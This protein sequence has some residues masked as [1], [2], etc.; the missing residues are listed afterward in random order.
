MKQK[1][2]VVMLPTTEATLNSLVEYKDNVLAYVT[3]MLDNNH[4]KVYIPKDNSY[5]IEND[6]TVKP[7]HL[8]FLS[9]E[10]IKEGDWYIWGNGNNQIIQ[11]NNLIGFDDSVKEHC[12]KIIATTDP[13][14]R[15]CCGREYPQNCVIENKCP[16][17]PKVLSISQQD[18]PKIVDALNKGVT[19]VGI[20][21]YDGGIMETHHKG[22]IQT[23]DGCI[24]LDWGVEKLEDFQG[25]KILVN[26]DYSGDTDFEEGVEVFDWGI[27]K[28]E[29]LTPQQVIDRFGDHLTTEQWKTLVKKMYTK[30]EVEEL[31][32]SA[33][34]DNGG[35][36]SQEQITR[37]KEWIKENLKL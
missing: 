26:G 19:S 20:K 30:E 17:Y 35:F 27:I 16:D 5:S 2:P 7:Q 11:A 13:K 15:P 4:Y 14:L 25:D 9:D 12:K 24:V 34:E 10:K 6:T 23:K 29:L 8:H 31:C 28:K 37:F 32:T 22:Q 18:L 33:I 36:I 21:V 1:H 3:E